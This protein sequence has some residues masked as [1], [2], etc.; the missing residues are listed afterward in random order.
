M[1]RTAEQLRALAIAPWAEHATAHEV[2]AWAAAEFGTLLTVAASMQDGVLPHLVSQHQP[3]V[4]VLFLDTGYHFQ[5]TLD[6][7]ELVALHLPVTVV[8]V[9]PRLSVNEQDAAHG[10]RLYERDPAACCRMRKVEPLAE[11]LS[12]YEAW[13]TGVRREESAVR[14]GTPVVT[15]DEAHGLVKINPLAHWSLDD[16][17]DYSRKHRLPA[18]PLLDDG[19]PSIGCAPCTRTVAPGEDVRA[20]RWAGFEKT[21]CGIHQ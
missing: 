9:R 14:A 8:N 4:D 20:G 7:R 12:G 2:V 10:P 16:V 18:N 3:D 17:L 6:T 15:F 1:R 21:E 13:V 5:Q 11:Q 19:Y